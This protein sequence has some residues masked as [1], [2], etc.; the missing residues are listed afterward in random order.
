M[1]GTGGGG[2]RQRPWGSVSV[3]G[4]GGWRPE[5]EEDLEAH[6]QTLDARKMLIVGTPCSPPSPREVLAYFLL[7]FPPR[8]KVCPQPALSPQPC[9]WPVTLTSSGEAA[10]RHRTVARRPQ[11]H[12]Q[13]PEELSLV[14]GWNGDLTGVFKSFTTRMPSLIQIMMVTDTIQA[15]L[16]IWTVPGKLT[17]IASSLAL[18]LRVGSSQRG[19]TERLCRAREGLHR[20]AS[21][22][23]PL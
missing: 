23:L 4:G 17:C 20:T 8:R 2:Q 3:R 12:V 22:L 16:W 21:I 10:S 13:G 9:S 11:Q 1:P 5:D 14:S 15:L 19:A 7:G 18:L 6:F